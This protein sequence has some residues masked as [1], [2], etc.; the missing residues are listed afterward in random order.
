MNSE[1]FPEAIY[2][3]NHF[4]GRRF[5]RQLENVERVTSDGFHSCLKEPEYKLT[6]DGDI[7]CRDCEKPAIIQCPFCE[8]YF[9]C[10]CVEHLEITAL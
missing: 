1:S 4:L 6:P 5:R 3:Y 8:D 2:P 10:N 7:Q 9:C